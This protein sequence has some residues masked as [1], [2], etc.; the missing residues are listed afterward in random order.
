MSRDKLVKQFDLE[1]SDFYNKLSDDLFAKIY[2]QKCVQ[3]GNYVIVFCFEDTSAVGTYEGHSHDFG[4]HYLNGGKSKSR[5]LLCNHCLDM[6]K[7]VDEVKDLE[8]KKK[9][10]INEINRI[11]NKMEA[12][13]KDVKSWH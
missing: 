6:G 7:L 8:H 11:G 12:I 1:H 10:L 4:H 3:C 5:R 2:L 9:T 13:L